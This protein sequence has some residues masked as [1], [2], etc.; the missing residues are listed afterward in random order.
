MI[1]S[2]AAENITGGWMNTIIILAGFLGAILVVA[3]CR[4]PNVKFYSPVTLFNRKTKLTSTGANLYLVF[5]I[6][7][8]IGAALTVFGS[9][10]SP[11]RAALPACNSQD[12]Q[13]FLKDA[14]DQSQLARTENLSMV[15]VTNITD[16]SGT[17]VAKRRCAG[18]IT[19]NNTETAP[20]RY[21]F[22]ARDD[23]KVMVRFEVGEEDTTAA[24]TDEIAASARM[25]E[26]DEEVSGPSRV[27]PITADSA[28]ETQVAQETGQPP[29]PG[30][31]AA[32]GAVPDIIASFDCAKASSKIEKLIC[33]D[34]ATADADS[35]LAVTYREALSR[36]A[37]KAALKQSQCDWLFQTRNACGDTECLTRVTEE[38]IQTLAQLR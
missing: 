20:I 12:S 8:A 35:Q 28:N 30:G 24:E 13:K 10:S 38:R 5:L 37:D 17:D 1:A 9:I 31:I 27:Q 23:G 25:A 6:I 18:V 11:A 36:S 2:V 26:Q 34:A 19:L 4:Q 16:A 22:E 14:F 3:L 21:E 29:H 33:S 32:T 15:E 7:A